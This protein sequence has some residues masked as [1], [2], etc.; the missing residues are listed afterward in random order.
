MGRFMERQETPQPACP[1][2]EMRPLRTGALSGPLLGG[3][4]VGQF[5]ERKEDSAARLSSNLPS[6]RCQARLDVKRSDYGWTIAW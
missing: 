5:M 2:S 1:H 4:G 3:V 6:G